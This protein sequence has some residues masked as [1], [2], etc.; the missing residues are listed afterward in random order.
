MHPDPASR[1]RPKDAIRSVAEENKLLHAVIDNFP[2]GILLYDENLQL[3]VCNE[4]QKQLLEYPPAL[5]EYGMPTLEQIFRFN[6][7]RGEYGPGD[8]EAHVRERMRLAALCEPHVFER[9]RPNGTVLQIRGVPLCGGG[10]LTM[11]LD[12]TKEKRAAAQSPE[13]MPVEAKILYTDPLTALPNWT[14][15][16]DRFGQ[17]L[18][19]VKRGQIAAMHY[20]DLDRFKQVEAQLGQK[21]SDAL[22]GSVARRLRNMARATDTVTRLGEDEFLILQSEVDRPS[23]VARLSK[24]IVEAIRQPYE[25]MTH[26][27]SIGASI[28]LALIPRDGTVPEDLIGLAR[29]NMQRGRLEGEELE[30]ALNDGTPVFGV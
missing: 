12:I 8:V 5:F 28:G 17:V 19:R 7:I 1:A 24:R 20:V 14:L 25:I 26:R 11:Y 15:F 10:F 29:G 6:A 18:A 4:T 22:L 3:V 16:L 13:A 23:S 21:A 27:V 9:T 30:A 2:G